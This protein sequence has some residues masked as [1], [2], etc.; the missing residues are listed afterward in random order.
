M[1]A[2]HGQ[3]RSHAQNKIALLTP[4]T[5]GN[6]GDAAIQD[7]VIANV[8]RR[9]Q[10]AD[11]CLITLCPDYTTA[12][13]HVPSFPIGI[14]TFPPGPSIA[15]REGGTADAHPTHGHGLL[16]R[17]KATLKRSSLLYPFLTRLY[18]TALSSVVG[19]ALR[20]L[21]HIRRAYR[22]MRGVRLLIV[23]GGGQLDDYWGAWRHPYALFKWGLIARA[24]GAPYVYLS[25]GTC[26]L[27]LRSS[28]LLIRLALSLA[29]Y[30]SYR[31]HTSKQALKHLAF[32]RNDHVYPDLAFSY[33]A[34][35]LPQRLGRRNN[36]GRVVGVSPIAY[37]SPHG[38]PKTDGP[39]Y[40]RYIDSLVTFIANLMRQRY[41]IVLF[42]TDP[43]DRCAVNDV[44][45]HLA[46]EVS[47]DPLGKLYQPRTDT[48]D[49]LFGQL[50]NIDYVVASRLHGVL[51]PQL[52]CLPV[53]AISYD[54][55]VD[56]HMRDIG[57]AEYC[58]DIHSIDAASLR[59]T[60][61]SLT[62]AS[63]LIKS[64]LTQ[65]RDDYACALQH[66]YDVVLGP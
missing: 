24:V 53:L 34:G 3:P 11:I 28:A 12:L 18:R 51:L 9:H 5:G 48:L 61:A 65:K 30:R 62:M 25:V 7:A 27:E 63:E 29:A 46:E 31:D 6:L 37:L 38:W 1:L 55:K 33:V 36:I 58:L 47:L 42:S 21:L 17:V 40:E 59:N 64:R 20:E 57:L 10:D 44:L 23:S 14:T 16:T 54:R 49:A 22:L 50:T 32:T 13:H 2:R 15:Y 8:K 60:F 56:T 4:Y 43:V 66:Q 19:R 26:S 52:L 41:S 45:E 39:I 35:R